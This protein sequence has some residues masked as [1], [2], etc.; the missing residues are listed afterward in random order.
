MSVAT[1]EDVGLVRELYTRYKSLAL[2]AGAALVLDVSVADLAGHAQELLRDCR[3]AAETTDGRV[4]DQLAACESAVEDLRR[5]IAL[6]AT[7]TSAIS[8]ADTERARA[9]H[10]TLRHEVWRII[11]CEY[12]PCAAA[13]A[14]DRAA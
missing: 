1:E 4:H 14:R 5:L 13:H 10:S 2:A 11:P 9:S 6:A 7:G 8:A 3:D 12:V